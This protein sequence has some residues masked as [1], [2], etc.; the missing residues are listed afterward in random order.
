MI[1]RVIMKKRLS[2]PEN[3]ISVAYA[4]KNFRA[5]RKWSCRKR[6][7]KAWAGAVVISACLVWNNGLKKVDGLKWR[8]NDG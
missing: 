6:L 3:R 4:K 8:M 2:K 7:S 1:K 5:E